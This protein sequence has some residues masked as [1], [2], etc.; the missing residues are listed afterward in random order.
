MTSGVS[1]NDLMGLVDFDALRDKTQGNPL[2]VPDMV[3]D[4]V[5]HIDG[6]YLAYIVSADRLNQPATTMAQAIKHTHEFVEQL[7][8]YS[9]SEKYMIHLTEGSKGGRFEQALLKVYQ[10]NRDNKDKPLLLGDIR[11]YIA[12]EM[13][14][15]VCTKGEADDSMAMCL[16]HAR[17]AG[18]ED[19]AVLISQ[20]KDLNMVQGWHLDW[21]ECELY[22]VDAFGGLE[23]VERHIPEKKKIDDDGNEVITK[24]RTD[25]KLRGT[26]GMWFFAQLMMGD[27][28]DNISGL[29]KISGRILNEIKPTK[30]ITKA[31][32]VLADPDASDK[33]QASA[34]EKLS[35]RKAGSC[36]Q[37]ITYTYLKDCKTLREAYKKVTFA[38]ALYGAEIGF[39]DYEGNK[40]DSREAFES[41][42]KL[43]YMR[44]NLH[45]YDFKEF[46]ARIM[47]E[48]L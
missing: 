9:G 35:L 11:K 20:D 3:K 43:L 14:S 15:Y 39:K 31:K 32:E 25:K 22:Y 8:K 36:G 46:F 19:K 33:K 34:R 37:I 6:D 23:I 26:G 17:L 21:M 38:Y 30:E 45:E 7:M 13:S 24:A 2:P 18:N 28:A 42:C 44:H 10:A 12:K 1:L 27:S 29:P 5:A 41:E 40:I 4:R 47:A 16:H 48:E